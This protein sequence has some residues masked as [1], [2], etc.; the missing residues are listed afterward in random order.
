MIQ[1][2]HDSK[3]FPELQ[4]KKSGVFKS[5]LESIHIYARIHLVIM[6][7]QMHFYVPDKVAKRIK[8]N[9]KRLGIPSSKY[10]SQ[11]ITEKVE[12]SWPAGYIESLGKRNIDIKFDDD[13][14][15]PLDDIT[16]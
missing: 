15:L 5:P 13:D 2:I 1:Y 9:A 16:L 14:L 10:V 3:H 8:D 4:N 11:I 7:P 12:G 6:M